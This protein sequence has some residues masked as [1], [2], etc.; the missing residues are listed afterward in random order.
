MKLDNFLSKNNIELP[1]N[2]YLLCK[3][4]IEIMKRGT[5]TRHNEKHVYAIFNDLDRFLNEQKVID[6]NKI[7]FQILLLGISWHDTWR[8]SKEQTNIFF[9]YYHTL[10]HGLAATRLF[11]NHAKQ[12]NLNPKLIKKVNYAIRKHTQFQ[13]MSLNTIE[14][15]ILRDLDQ[16]QLWSIERIRPSVEKYL[17]PGKENVTMM[18]LAKFYYLK[19]MIN[20]NNSKLHFYWSKYEFIKRKAT[21]DKRVKEFYRKYKHLI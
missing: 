21:F 6:I 20:A 8:A 19:F 14:A 1:R 17:I 2:I 16:L 10:I 5:D 4:G 12:V 15:K 18:K 13:F 9:I 7:N 11:K 3:K